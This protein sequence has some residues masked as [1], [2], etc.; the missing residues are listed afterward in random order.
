MTINLGSI[1][2][3]ND[4]LMW[5]ETVNPIAYEYLE[6]IL[7]SVVAGFSVYLAPT[8][9]KLGFKPIDNSWATHLN[10]IVKLMSETK[11]IFFILYVFILTE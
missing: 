11:A 5:S 10:K 1:V 6:L 8:I 7:L 9:K 4:L 3:P 2:I